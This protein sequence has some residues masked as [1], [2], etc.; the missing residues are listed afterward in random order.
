MGP[1]V[2]QCVVERERRGEA[3]GLKAIGRVCVASAKFRGC[4]K[5]DSKK[6]TQQRIFLKSEMPFFPKQVQGGMDPLDLF[7]DLP[8][9]KHFRSPLYVH[10]YHTQLKKRPTLYQT[11][12]H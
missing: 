12:L 3:G 4:A 9:L 1:S 11:A 10:I 6:N 8:A 7:R 2:R 5:Y